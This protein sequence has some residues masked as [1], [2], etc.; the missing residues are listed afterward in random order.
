[1]RRSR[2]RNLVGIAASGVLLLGAGGAAAQ[3]AAAPTSDTP[4]RTVTTW[5]A[6]DDMAGGTLSDMTVR[7]V[8]HTSIGGSGLRVRLS[9]AHGTHAVTFDSVYVGLQDDGPAIVPGSNRRVSFGG[10]TT[11]VIPPGATALSDPLPRRVEP[12]QKLSISIHVVGDSGALTAHNRTMQHTYKSISG[13]HAADEGAAAFQTQS[14]VW[15]W[16]DAVVVEA[17]EQTGTVATIGDSI[18]A[19]VG[20]TVNADRRWPDILADRFAALPDVRQMGVANEGISGNRVLDGVSKPGSAGDSALARLER[21]VLTKPGVETVL[22]FE[23]V[24]DV[25]AGSTAAEIIAGYRQL[26]V[27]TRAADVCIVGAT[28]LPFGGSVY[29]DPAAED[30][31]QAVND[32]IRNSGDFDA[33]VDFDAATR[34]EANPARLRPEFHNGDGLHPNDAGNAAMAAAIDLDELRC[35]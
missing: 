20:T 3:I 2:L 21:D 5:A 9:N 4:T 35:D 27:R 22:L 18:T 11:V 7:N 19:G 13:D 29:G 34:D 28:I 10:S 31:R 24:N 14:A 25:G 17:P 12:Q 16:L 33:V 6:S 15:Y 23:G 32:Y 26:V 8:V 1:M 30:T